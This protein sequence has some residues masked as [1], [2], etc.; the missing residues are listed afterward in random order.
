MYN[1]WQYLHVL[2]ATTWVGAGVLSVFL[3]LR[4]GALRDNPVAGAAYGL[5]EKSSVPLF[6]VSSFGT[7]IT[8]LVLAF[9]WV[10]FEPLWIKI[11]LG[12]VILSIVVGIAYFAPLGKKV[13]AATEAKDPAVMAMVRQAQIVS[14]A[15]LVLFAVIVW[16]MVAKPV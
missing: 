12:G 1:F 6:I 15:E 13:E 7:L 16:A 14:V 10:T 2:F 8:G 11:G 3:S 5:M 9:G 4:L